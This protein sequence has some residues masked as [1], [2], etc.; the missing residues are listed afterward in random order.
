MFIIITEIIIFDKI[1][2]KHEKM[3]VTIKLSQYSS[4]MQIFMQN[5]SQDLAIV[6]NRET[7]YRNIYNQ[8]KKNK[9][10]K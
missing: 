2:G 7:Y 9:K 8:P 6:P 4:R 3:L 10:I 1:Y 5:H